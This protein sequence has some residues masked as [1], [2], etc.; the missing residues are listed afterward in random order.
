MGGWLRGATLSA[1]H[2]L[3]AVLAVS[4]S[5]SISDPEGLRRGAAA[6]VGQV[7]AI[8]SPPKATPTEPRG[9]A[10]DV[11][12]RHDLPAGAKGVRSLEALHGFPL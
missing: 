12:P 2:N 7:E 3:Q 6:G 8:S 5:S 9:R 10:W 4:P 11:S 1:D